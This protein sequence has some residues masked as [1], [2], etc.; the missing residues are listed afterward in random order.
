MADYEFK[1]C[2]MRRHQW[3]ETGRFLLKV[4]GDRSRYIVFRFVCLTCDAKRDDIYDKNGDLDE[5]RYSM[6]RGYLFHYT[7][8]EREAGQ[9]VTTR[10]V[11]RYFVKEALRD[12]NIPEIRE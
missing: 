6:P 2:R 8:E 4:E 1:P 11:A 9:R 5:R 7:Q 3:E 12:K 10:T